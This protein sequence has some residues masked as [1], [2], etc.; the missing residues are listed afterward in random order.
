MNH[1]Q[2]CQFMLSV[3]DLAQLPPDHGIEIAIVGRSNAGK[4]TVLNKITQNKG[5][6]RVSKRLVELNL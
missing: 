4:S 1:Y 2:N 6:A 3:A 5:L